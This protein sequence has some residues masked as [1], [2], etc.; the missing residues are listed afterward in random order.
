MAW[1]LPRLGRYGLAALLGL[2]ATATLAQGTVQAVPALSGHVIDHTATLSAAQQQAI[3][4]KLAAFEQ[5]AGT[6][7]VV[8]VVPT[9]AP[10]DI[11][12]YA[13]R[14]GNS[15]K[16]GR[17]DV[18]DGLLL[19]VAK[20]DR[21]LRIEVA[22]A[23]EGAVP[24]L[25]AKQ[26]IDQAIAPRFKQGDF[27]GGIEAGVDR[28]LQ[29]LQK[30]APALEQAAIQAGTQAAQS[31]AAQIEA[32]M[33]AAK[34]HY[35]LTLLGLFVLSSAVLSPV[36]GGLFTCIFGGLGYT[37]ASVTT[38]VSYLGSTWYWSAVI[39]PAVLALLGF[40]VLMLQ[41][42]TP[43]SQAATTSPRKIAKSDSGTSWWTSSTS[44]SSSDSSG[45]GFFSS[46]GGGDFG[47][48]G[49]SGDW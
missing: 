40:I 35:L 10:E 28:L 32:D 9:T 37:I 41:P 30:E 5:S 31:A 27:A 43:K 6:Q 38:L 22:K 17:K 42:S 45:G 19:I 39:G 47:G 24:D 34:G 7:L 46:G 18:G 29:L 3:E 26:V 15:W 4:S 33:D 20:N 1:T 25:A 13:N 23:L 2:L 12:S 44:G 14:V 49:A 36:G 16:I 48:G 21:K 11:A 8:L